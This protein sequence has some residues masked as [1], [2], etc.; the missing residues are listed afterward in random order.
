MHTESHYIL[1]AI[2]AGAKGFVIKTHAADDLVQ[3][4]REAS[5]G[6]TY[7]SPEVSRALVDGY[8]GR[9]ALRP[10]PLSPKERRV[11]QLIAEGQTTKEL[12]AV[13]NI[14]VKTAETHRTRIMTKLNIHETA[15]LVRY[16]IRRG[17]VQP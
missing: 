17:L 7:L 14:S 3:A 9:T 5:R 11:L 2:R 13:L 12:A 16:A 8:Q 6:G 4:L 15:S 10:D 1:Q